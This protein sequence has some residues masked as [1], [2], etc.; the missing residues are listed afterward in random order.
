MKNTAAC[1]L[2]MANKIAE[3]NPDA[4]MI[5]LPADHL[6]LKEDVFWKKWSWHLIWLQT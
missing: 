6:I 2:Y 3:I 5:V 4:T 1:N